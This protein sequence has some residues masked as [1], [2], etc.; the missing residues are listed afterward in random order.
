MRLQEAYRAM[1]QVENPAVTLVRLLKRYLW[2][3]KDDGSLANVCVGQEWYDRELLKDYDGQVT[4]GL[5]RNEEYKLSLNGDLRRRL[6][7]ARINVWVTDKPDKGVAGRSMR[8]K[9]CVE[10]N[11]VIREKRNSPNK[12]DYDYIGV[13]SSSETH[14]AYEAASD[15]E[16]TPSD[17]GWSEF[18]DADYQKIW[19]SDDERFSKSVLE[20][21]KCAFM[22]FRFQ[23]DADREVVKEMVLKFEGYGTAPAGNGATVK[24]WNHSAEAWQNAIS[25]AGSTDETLTITL[26][27]NLQNYIDADGNVYLLAQTSN[28]SDGVTPAVLYCDYVQTE[29][30]V[31]GIT[32]ADVAGFRDVDEVRV[33][34]FL[35]RTEFVVKTWLFETVYAT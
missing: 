29:F 33:K 16:P 1:S 18:T 35:W 26:S 10:V 32:Y 15:S 28:P 3:V 21:G 17:S 24:V 25:G 5:E 11:Q 22:L 2:V 12:I 6:T 13:G 31:N 9:I 34:P 8:E 23:I 7:F 4:V 30:T 19:H 27:S 20:N 14:K